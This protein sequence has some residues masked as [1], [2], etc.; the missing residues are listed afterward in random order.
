[1]HYAFC[2]KHHLITPINNKCYQYV[3]YVQ[4][5]QNVYV[6]QYFFQ[7]VV[8]Q[9]EDLFFVFMHSLGLLHEITKSYKK[10]TTT[11]KKKTTQQKKQKTLSVAV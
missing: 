10:K 9:E 7:R 5:V 4:H 11:T 8:V 2:G 3:Q 6:L 1:M